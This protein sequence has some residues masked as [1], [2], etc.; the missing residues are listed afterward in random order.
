MSWFFLGVERGRRAPAAPHNTQA[1]PRRATYAGAH[2]PPSS[3]GGDGPQSAAE[4][5]EA[6][7]LERAAGGAVPAEPACSPATVARRASVNGSIDQSPRGT[8]G[9]APPPHPPAFSPPAR[10]ACVVFLRLLQQLCS[11]GAGGHDEEGG[12]SACERVRHHQ[13]GQHESPAG[14]EAG[15]EAYA[16]GTTPHRS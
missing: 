8:R 2:A 5:S 7:G 9:G 6:A 13:L 16:R 3:R 4:R 15:R 12:H 10:G 11:R 1:G 14:R